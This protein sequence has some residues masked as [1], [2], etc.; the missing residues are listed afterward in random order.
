MKRINRIWPAENFD[1][2]AN[3]LQFSSDLHL[4]VKFNSNPG[5]FWRL[6]YVI[7]MFTFAGPDC[8]A[9][10]SWQQWHDNYLA[11]RVLIWAFVKPELGKIS[12][13]A[14]KV[15]RWNILVCCQSGIVNNFSK[16]LLSFSSLCVAFVWLFSTVPSEISKWQSEPLFRA[17]QALSKQT[18]PRYGIKL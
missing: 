7:D 15:A 1:I 14:V 9:K 16:Q 4:H 17:T 10:I 8:K 18:M 13:C 12:R 2:V 3:S 5:N 6:V 11:I